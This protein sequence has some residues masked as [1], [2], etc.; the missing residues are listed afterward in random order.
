M[1]AYFVYVYREVIDCDLL[2]TYG[3]KSGPTLD[4]YQPRSIAACTPFQQ[5]EGDSVDGVAVIEFPSAAIARAWY[6]SPGYQAIR[7]H[8]EAGAHTIG[9]LVEG[10]A[11]PLEQRMAHTKDRRATH[12]PAG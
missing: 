7:H 2:E 8:R 12:A 5:L 10:G 9:L 1:P 11:L 4:C 3:S 6:D